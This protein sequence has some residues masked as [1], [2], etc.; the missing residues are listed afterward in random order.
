MEHFHGWGTTDGFAI[1]ILGPLLMKYPRPTLQLL[2]TWNRSANRWQRR[3]SVVA[4]TRQ[5]GASGRFTAEV[6]RLCDTL[7]W[8]PDDL[9]QKAVGWALKDNMR[10]NKPKVCAYVRRLRRMGV[11][12]TITLYAM[13]DLRGR[14]RAAL[15]KQQA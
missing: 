3:A 15:L 2:R 4:F 6:L 13:R 14:E 8:D 1:D 12:A 11:P 7:I 9:V 5:V 10:K